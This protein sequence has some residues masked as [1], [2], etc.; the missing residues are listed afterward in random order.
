MSTLTNKSRSTSGLNLEAY[1]VVVRPVVTE[2]SIQ[3]SETTNQYTFE[4]HPQ[5]DKVEIRK[6]IEELFDVKVERVCTQTRKGKPRRYR[7]QTGHTRAWKKAIG[8]L[9]ADD[10][11]NLF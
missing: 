7:A 3:L 9:N 11:I 8:T 6:A 5:A 10:R 4:V 1:Q 2:K